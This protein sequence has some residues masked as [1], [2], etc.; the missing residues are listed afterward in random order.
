MSV[1]DPTSATPPTGELRSDPAVQPLPWAQLP[2]VQGFGRMRLVTASSGWV[3]TDID[4]R[5]TDDGGATWSSRPLPQTDGTIGP[6]SFIDTE[7]LAILVQKRDASSVLQS[8]D[9]GLTWRSTL[10][11]VKRQ[12]RDRRESLTF[13]D[14]QTGWLFRA[15]ANS[16]TTGTVYS[17]TDGGTTWAG[18]SEVNTGL[19]RMSMLRGQ[20]SELPGAILTW[21]NGK[22][23]SVP[24]DDRLGISSDGGAHWH[25]ATLPTPV[26]I[27]AGLMKMNQG[28]FLTSTGHPVALIA[29]DAGRATRTALFES[30]DGSNWVRRSA[31]LDDASRG[32]WQA[33]FASDRD[34]LLTSSD[35][36]SSLVT[37]DGG[38]TWRSIVGSFTEGTLDFFSFATTRDGWAVQL[39]GADHET[40]SS[41]GCPAPGS[42]LWSTH[43]SGKSWHRVASTADGIP[44]KAEPIVVGPDGTV[45][46]SIYDL[47]FRYP[48]DWVVTKSESDP[49]GRAGSFLRA[50]GSVGTNPVVETCD[51]PKVNT[52]FVGKLNQVCSTT[53]DPSAAVQVRFEIDARVGAWSLWSGVIGPDG[54]DKSTTTVAGLPALVASANGDIVP[55]SS[56]QA[57]GARRIVVWSIASQRRTSESTRVTAVFR[58]SDIE[59]LQREVAKMIASME[60]VPPVVPLATDQA[61]RDAAVA[62]A[63]TELSE[64]AART[65]GDMSADCFT[66]TLD[67]PN[68]ARI[69]GTIFLGYRLTSPLDVRCSTHVEPTAFQVWRLTLRYEWDAT[70]AYPAGSATNTLFLSPDGGFGGEDEGVDT[71]PGIVKLTG[72]P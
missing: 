50:L 54:I 53:W 7:N 2:R 32:S 4:L 6:I 40:A 39:C 49:N 58:G 60:A 70:T 10:S 57:L 67:T 29:F 30:P 22:A 52:G 28:T 15:P 16:A 66:T 25:I 65:E 59:T 24:F 43:N 27:P 3:R 62:D 1:A 46:G 48:A 71:I 33:F 34:W 69:S 38:E 17:T 19:G 5:F 35:G 23:D 14:A 20:D 8:K 55:G 64:M 45:Q 26:G 41:S 61:S 44:P 47:R 37:S 51:W 18:P 42:N 36:A 56:E 68:A 72:N 13:A 12:P 11:D 21:E 63:I 9:G 31:W